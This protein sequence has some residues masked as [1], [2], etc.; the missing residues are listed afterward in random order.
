MSNLTLH[1]NQRLTPLQESICDDIAGGLYMYLA[2]EKHGMTMS[3]LQRLRLQEPVFDQAVSRARALSVD[4]KVDQL[5]DTATNVP[6]VQRARLI[7]ENIKWTAARLHPKVYGDKLDITVTERVDLG[8]ALAAARA[9]ALRPLCDPADIIEVEVIDYKDE[10]YASAVD[11][12][13]ICN[14]IED[15]MPDIFS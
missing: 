13:S 3:Q 4:A 2:A 7:C 10:T 9:R 6:D 11:N 12:E 1:T 8:D 15:V 14:E 5:N